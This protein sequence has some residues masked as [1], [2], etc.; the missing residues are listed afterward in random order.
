MTERWLEALGDAADGAIIIDQEQRIIFCNQAAREI[1]GH[2]GE[3]IAGS[4]CYATLGGRSKGGLPICREQC[5]C[6]AA[7]AKGQPVKSFD[8]SVKTQPTGIQWLNVSTVAWPSNG[9]GKGTEILHLFR[10]VTE[11]K[12]RGQLLD[13]VLEA[14]KSLQDG[15]HQVAFASQPAAEPGAELTDREREV[16]S[17]LAEGA[18][19]CGI[20]RALVIS[21]S[22]TRNHIRN[23]LNKFQVHS[24]LEAVLYALR[25]GL[26]N[27]E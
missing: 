10:D 9:A 12:K 1:I 18:D 16:L 19:T 15:G 25:H 4:F 14:A 6:A 3:E 17:L 5:R 26:V 8:M 27:I 13:R 22:T 2:D 21:P 24:R 7:A 23:I 20:A 11:R